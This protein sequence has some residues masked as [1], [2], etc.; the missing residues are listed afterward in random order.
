MPPTLLLWTSP[1]L[2]SRVHLLTWVLARLLWVLAWELP[3]LWVL[4][5]LLLSWE[6]LGLHAT[7]GPCHV[8]LRPTKLPRPCWP[9]SEPSPTHELVLLLTWELLLSRELALLLARKLLGLLPGDLLAWEL[10]S[11]ELLS[12]LLGRLLARRHASRGCRLLPPERIASKWIRCTSSSTILGS[13]S[14]YAE[15]VRIEWGCW[16]SCS[17]VWRCI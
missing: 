7:C 12:G 10:L 6:S 5:L 13:L 4:S 8:T 11:G 1:L 14:W 9:P 17:R 3:L 16:C 15:R 2:L